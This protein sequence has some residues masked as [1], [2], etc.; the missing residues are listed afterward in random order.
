ME[1]IEAKR[2]MVLDSLSFFVQERNKSLFQLSTAKHNLKIA[3]QA[4]I[5]AKAKSRQLK[6]RLLVEI[7]KYSHILRPEDRSN[8]I[9]DE[10]DSN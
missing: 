6:T 1:D 2:Q 10:D 9:G 4:E 7:D 5:D 8:L 3:K